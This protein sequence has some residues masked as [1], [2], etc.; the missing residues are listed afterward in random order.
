MATARTAT[1]TDSECGRPTCIEVVSD[2]E[3]ARIATLSAGSFVVA[4]PL[5]VTGNYVRIALVGINMA[6]LAG[7]VLELN[8]RVGKGVVLEVIEPVGMVAYNAEGQGAAWRLRANCD[9]GA[10]LIW[11]GAPFVAAHGSNVRRLSELALASGARA[12]I[13]ESLVLGRSGEQRPPLHSRMHVSLDE[14]E[15]LVEDL[16]I[17]EETGRL[18][19]IVERSRVIVT[20]IAAGWRP[21][22]DVADP[23]RLD[24]A[25]PG[26][27][28][29]ALSSA[30]HHA[31]E[32]I[33]P[34]F[35]NWRSQLL[36]DRR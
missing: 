2:G 25:G 20:L 32:L 36:K 30:L 13:R 24:L 27:V 26:A 9:V 17:N 34:P 31:D 11:R 35:L 33:D 3:S 18:P 1:T 29:R 7:D 19:G 6:L 4:R 14:R 23:H 10:T 12:L 21:T 28:F 5:R 8:V 15:L 16:D 22:S